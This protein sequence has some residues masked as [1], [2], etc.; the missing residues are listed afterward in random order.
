MNTQIKSIIKSGLFSGIVYAGL[1]AGFDYSD[2]QDF[3]I[4]KF[5][6]HASF[7]GTFMAL[8][9]RYNLKKQADKE[10]NKTE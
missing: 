7:F 6:F 10:K 9:T 1:M 8:M 5:I 4:W 2:G 3:K